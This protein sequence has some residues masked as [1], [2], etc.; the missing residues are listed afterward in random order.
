MKN[1]IFIVF[2]LFTITAWACP[3]CDSAAA[4]K[5]QPP[6][7]LIILGCFILLTYIPFYIFYRSAKNFDPS[8]L[9]GNE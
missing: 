1:L 2:S 6:Y 5:N 9:N 7:T 4:N 3:G 8:K